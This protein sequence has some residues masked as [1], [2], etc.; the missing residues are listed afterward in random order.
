LLFVAR[1]FGITV[2]SHAAYDL[3][4]GILIPTLGS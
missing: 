2:G 1:G 3:F 4:V